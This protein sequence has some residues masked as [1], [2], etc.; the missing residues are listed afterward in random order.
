MANGRPADGREIDDLFDYDIDAN[1][2]FKDDYRPPVPVKEKGKSLHASDAATKAGGELGLDEEVKIPRKPRAPR[3]KLD[4]N[5]LLSAAGIPKLQSRAKTLKFKGKGHEYSDASRLLNFYQI[6]L[7]DI[8]PKA[9]FLDAAAMVE[10][11]GHKKQIQIM[12]TEWI[13]GPQD[14]PDVR[15]GG[16]ERADQIDGQRTGERLNTP[17]ISAQVEE[18]LYNATPRPTNPQVSHS[19]NLSS[20]SMHDI[21]HTSRSPER[22]AEND[23]FEDELDDLLAADSNPPLGNPHA[24]P[25]VASKLTESNF[26]DDEQAMAEME[27]EW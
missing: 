4:E 26:D 3:V 19:L 1:D 13:K 27:M 16:P 17:E 20:L 25:L 18:D 5:L 22:A 8:F 14:T 23:S 24:T 15:E 7:D 21:R 11:L 12:R 6:W 9:K 2:P 10:K